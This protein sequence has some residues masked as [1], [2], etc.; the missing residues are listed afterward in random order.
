LSDVVPA[1]RQVSILGDKQ[2]EMT[3]R[4]RIARSLILTP[5]QP[6][7]LFE[8]QNRYGE[9]KLEKPNIKHQL[10]PIEYKSFPIF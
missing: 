2:E 8:Y 6:S 4:K 7:A 9:K 10:F 3:A 1:L 5:R